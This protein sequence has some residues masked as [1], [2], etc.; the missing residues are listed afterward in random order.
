[1]QK[2]KIL[3]ISNALHESN[4]NDWSLPNP[5]AF[6]KDEIAEVVSWVEDGGSLMLIADHMPCPGAA[7]D[8]AAAFGFEFNN[9]FARD[10]TRPSNDFFQ[11]E[12]DT[13]TD[14]AI[15]NGRNKRERVDF[16]VS[17]TGQ[18]FRIPEGAQPLLVL[19]SNF[20]SLMPDTAWVFRPWTT[21]IDV[22]GW[23]QGAY[24]EFGKGRVA[25]FGEAAMFTAQ[26]SGRN[27]RKMGMNHPAAEQNWQFLLNVIHWL[28][29]IIE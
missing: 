25:V 27:R 16:V 20:I 10:T 15:T 23:S 17:F 24:R 26:V 29:G 9:G 12:Q 8:L 22:G 18:A 7:A 21:Q 19:N 14:N 13:L 4:I 3:V 28:D 11:R 6:T 1:M 5:S 2:A